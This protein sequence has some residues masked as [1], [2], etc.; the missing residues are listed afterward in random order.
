MSLFSWMDTTPSPKERVEEMLDEFYN[1][2]PWIER[3]DR[4]AL[5]KDFQAIWENTK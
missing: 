1:K 3:D 2:Y 4:K 5:E